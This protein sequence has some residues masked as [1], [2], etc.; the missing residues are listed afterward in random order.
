MLKG[1][2]L[3]AAVEKAIALKLE[4]GSIRFKKEVSDHFGIKQ[5]SMADWIKKGSISKERLPELWRYFADVAGPSHWGLS[6]GEWPSELS[7][8]IE[9]G[10]R[11]S[12]RR[13]DAPR[14]VDDKNSV[15]ITSKSASTVG[16]AAP[17]KLITKNRREER[18]EEIIALLNQT[19][20]DGL[21]VMLERAKDAAK[22]YPIAKQT[23][24][25]TG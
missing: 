12:R 5:P 24:A 2:E 15:E 1:K 17:S 9:V 11:N 21:A 18:I 25:S 20:T 14:F 10:E 19:D 8:S 22:D 13:D 3:G 6:P 7:R 4:R 16:V 23:P